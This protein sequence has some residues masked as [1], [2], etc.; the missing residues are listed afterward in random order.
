MENRWDTIVVGAGL[1]GLTAAATLAKEGQR[2]LVLEKNPHP[3]GT[4]YTFARKGFTFPMG[5]LGFS[6]P[7]RVRQILKGLAADDGLLLRR[8]HYR[9]KAFG[10]DIHLSLSFD[11]LARSLQEMFP[12]EAAGLDRFFQDLRAVISAMQSPQTPG[13]DTFLKDIAKVSAAEYIRSHIQDGRLHRVLGSLGTHEPYSTM[14]LMAAMWNLMS[15]EGIWYPQGGMR[16]FC[17]R[18][19]QAVL[20]P[21]DPVRSLG[22]LETGRTVTALTVH[23]GQVSG[24][25]LADGTELKARHVISNA[26]FKTTFLKLIPPE[27]LPDRWYR[28]VAGARQTGSI[29]QV[30]LGLKPGLADLSAFE[31]AS[32]LLYRQPPRE[33]GKEE[34]APDWGAATVD[35]AALARQELEISLLSQEDPALAPAGGHVLA[36]RTEADYHHFSRFRSPTG[37]RDLT[38]GPY[39]TDLARALIQAAEGILPGLASAIEVSDIATPLTFEDQGGRSEGAVAGWSWDYEDA[40][41]YEPVEAI[42]TPLRGL[43]MAGYQ[44]YSNLFMGGVPTAMV[45]GKRAAEY[46][47]NGTAPA[48]DLGIPLGRDTA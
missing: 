34:D 25:H 13:N 26:D 42:R 17:D 22:E 37:R 1:G 18:M 43:F 2:V 29:F 33:A 47:L 31:E 41:D 5:P 7:S 46:V 45:S 20:R 27:I 15:N 24:V 44:A 3:G 8:V 16:A 14:A 35:P 39:K 11:R 10:L 36:I 38:Y 9:V 19:V 32:R 12:A 23:E 40:A 4:A 28:Q 48:T 6:T 21:S 30:C